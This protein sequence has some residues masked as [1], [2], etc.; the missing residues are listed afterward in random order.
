MLVS[1]VPLSLTIVSG[2]PRPVAI[3]SNSRPT[4]AHESDPSGDQREALAGE[5]VYDRQHAEPP[6]AGKRVADEV[7]RPALVSTQRQGHRR[8]G[9]ER[10]LPAATTAHM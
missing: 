1:S 3:T 4:L 2:L 8:P 9:A 10:P 5:V 6:A 7:Q